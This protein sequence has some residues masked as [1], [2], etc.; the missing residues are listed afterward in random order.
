MLRNATRVAY[1]RNIQHAP[2]SF[3]CISRGC[4]YRLRNNKLTLMICWNLEQQLGVSG[5]WQEF[6]LVMRARLKCK[7]EQF[8]WV[9]LGRLNIIFLA[10]S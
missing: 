4:Q 9:F 6:G 2:R 3:W 10:L 5:K 8:L 1:K 7:K